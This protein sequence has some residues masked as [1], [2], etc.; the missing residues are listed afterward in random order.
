MAER[1]PARLAAPLALLV[2]AVAV[3]IVVAASRSTSSSS[4]PAATRTTIT[5]PA[6]HSR[7]AVPHVYVVKAGDTLSVIADRAGVSLDEIQRLN[8]D[9]DPNAL[10]TGERLKLSP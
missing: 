2:A 5:Q 4:A 10:Q 1:N 8:P 9:V 7:R 3:V 6:R